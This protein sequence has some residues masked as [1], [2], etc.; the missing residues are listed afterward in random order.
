F[1]EENYEVS[2]NLSGLTEIGKI[3]RDKQWEKQEIFYDGNVEMILFSN[4][5]LPFLKIGTAFF[6]NAVG[7]TIDHAILV[8]FTQALLQCLSMV[9]TSVLVFELHLEKM[10]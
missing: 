6:Q 8:G 2:N 1:G 7:K 5:Y 3:Y 4:Y 9:S 10:E